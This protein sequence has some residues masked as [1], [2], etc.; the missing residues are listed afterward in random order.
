MMNELL[1]EKECLNLQGKN[2]SREAPFGNF[3]DCLC[4]WDEQVNIDLRPSV[5]CLP[6]YR[7]FLI[8]IFTFLKDSGVLNIYIFRNLAIHACR[9]IV[10]TSH[11]LKR[12]SFSPKR[13]SRP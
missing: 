7:L 4:A 13:V 2:L 11:A 8:N 5:L 1:T 6:R 10:E 12:S 9:A 3:L